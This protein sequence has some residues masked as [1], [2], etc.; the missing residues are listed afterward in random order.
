MILKG[1]TT[2]YIHPTISLYPH[3]FHKNSTIVIN[4][5]KWR[6]NDQIKCRIDAF[7][8]D[9]EIKNSNQRL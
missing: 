4:Q 6:K 5:I 1:I 9:L 3:Q 7:G 8:V 2:R